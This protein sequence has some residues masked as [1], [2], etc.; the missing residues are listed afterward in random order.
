MS[1]YF[2]VE[3]NVTDPQ[4]YAEYRKLVEP[5]LNKYGGKFLVRGGAYE[6][7]EG[8]WKPQRF[9]ITEFENK[10]QFQSWYNSPEY[11]VAKNIRFRAA[12]SKGILIEGV[13]R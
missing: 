11:T 7:I 6:T 10:S 1:V 8:D 2:V 3:V 9:V 13:Q 12:T 5:T 4:L